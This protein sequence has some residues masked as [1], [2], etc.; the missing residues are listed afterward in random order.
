[1]ADCN[2]IY[3]PSEQPGGAITCAQFDLT[4]AELKIICSELNSVGGGGTLE[5]FTVNNVNNVVLSGAPSVGIT[6]VHID[7]L[8]LATAEYSLL[9]ATVTFTFTIQNSNNGTGS[10]VVQVLYN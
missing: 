10:S 1:M 4:L 3:V 2:N 5:E 8:K 7:G 9:G 6:D